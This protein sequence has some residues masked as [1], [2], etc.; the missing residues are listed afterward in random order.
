M[1]R[2]GS[3]FDIDGGVSA[4][5]GAGARPLPSFRDRIIELRRVRAGE[6]VPHPGKYRV[7]TGAQRAFLQAGL[8]EIGHADALIAMRLPDGRL[9]LINGHMRADM[10]PHAWVPVLILDVTKEE[11]DKLLLMLDPIAEMAQRDSERIR[12][13]L[14]TVQT[15][16]HALRDLFRQVAGNRIWELVHPGDIRD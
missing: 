9:M 8:E 11:A 1:E 7:H 10:D 2:D 14:S 6:L 13:L 12:A 5:T 4:D 3:N 16:N 15:E